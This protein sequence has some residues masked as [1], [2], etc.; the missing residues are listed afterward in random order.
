MLWVSI[1][2]SK[3]TLFRL[4]VGVALVVASVSIVDMVWFVLFVVAARTNK[5]SSSSALEDQD[6]PNV[7]ASYGNMGVVLAG[8]GKYEE[9][10]E[11]HTK[12]LEIRVHGDSHPP[13]ADSFNNLGA[14]SGSKG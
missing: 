8:M 6:S 5:R 10:L 12:S 11:M 2:T 1:V 9:A 4:F 3:S 13:V 14:L 7:A